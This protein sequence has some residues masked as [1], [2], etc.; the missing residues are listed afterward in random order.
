MR[1][2]IIILVSSVRIVKILTS[3][4]VSLYTTTVYIEPIVNI[5]TKLMSRA[6]VVH[7]IA[8][9]ALIESYNNFPPILGLRGCGQHQP[10]YIVYSYYKYMLVHACVCMYIL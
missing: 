3:F 7:E 1:V 10:I 4:D 9:S 5:M 6:K 8:K 2:I